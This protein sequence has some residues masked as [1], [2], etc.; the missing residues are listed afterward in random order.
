MCGDSGWVNID[1]DLERRD[2]IT[3]TGLAIT[4]NS[5][6]GTGPGHMSANSGDNTETGNKIENQI[7]CIDVLIE[8]SRVK[9]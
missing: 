2:L 8:S 5:A 3:N 4:N 7:V 1:N 6:L 9:M